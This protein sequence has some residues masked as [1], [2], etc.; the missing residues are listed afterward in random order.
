MH[1]A[2]RGVDMTRE[3]FRARW[4]ARLNECVKL[5]ILVDGERFCR[6][7]LADFDAVIRAE[8]DRLLSLVEASDASGYCKDHLRRLYRQGALPGERRGRRIFFRSADL[9]R[10]PKSE[11]TQ[12]FGHY[13]PVVDAR[14]LMARLTRPPEA[15][16]HR[17]QNLQAPAT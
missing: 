17:R 1:P 5:G 12:S 15:R 11:R 9:P 8:E 13:D 4:N 2:F 6:E 10:K 3:E 14:Q 7:V 16:R